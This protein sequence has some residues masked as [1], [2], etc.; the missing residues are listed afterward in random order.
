LEIGRALMSM[1]RQ[2][3]ASGRK[4]LMETFA[5]GPALRGLVAEVT[6]VDLVRRFASLRCDDGAT[7]RAV[8]Q[9]IARDSGVELWSLRE[10]HRVRIEVGTNNRCRI[11]GLAE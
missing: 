10:G 7:Y 3:K 11:T 1:H 6:D 4:I 8:E 5:D 9:A 2:T